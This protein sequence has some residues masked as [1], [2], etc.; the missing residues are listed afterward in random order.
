MLKNTKVLV[1]FS[2]GVDSTASVI[3]LQ[4]AGYEVVG[5]CFNVIND[6]FP[7]KIQAAA[8]SL[9]IK[10][11]KVCVANQFKEKVIDV[12]KSEY[13]NGRTP[14]PCILCNPAIK[15]K[16]LIEYADKEG[17]E[18]IATGH[19]AGIQ[20]I[21][22]VYYVKKA[23]NLA[24]DQSY[25]LYRLPQEVLKRLILP[26]KGAQSKDDVRTLVNVSGA[27]NANDKDS[28]DICFILDGDYKAYL[29][30]IG[31]KN[32]LGNFLDT[33]GNIIGK[34]QGILNYTIGQRKGLG[35]TFGRPAYVVEFKGNDV[36]LGFEDDLFK[37]IV[38]VNQL[39]WTGEAPEEGSK[40]YCKLRYSAKDAICEIHYIN[41]DEIQLS[42]EEAQRAPT[43]GQAAVLYN[44]NLVI[45]GGFIVK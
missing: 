16:T 20:C 26:L 25:M 3:L 22:G 18:Y 36:I 44:N 1:G 4:K 42:F 7:D 32:T 40:L 19:Y 15:F 31:A 33:K 27:P 10:L 17:C 37:K 2:G 45:G 14:N 23:V 34:H 24:K 38:S 21:S 9:G 43:P 29:N 41:Q 13:E 12:F 28:Q 11:I 6:Y 8:D 30:S 5:L 35:V 39:F